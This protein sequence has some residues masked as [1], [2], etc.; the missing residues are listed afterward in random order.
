M[1]STVTVQ[2][3][4]RTNVGLRKCIHVEHSQNEASLD[5][6]IIEGERE[7][8]RSENIMLKKNLHLEREKTI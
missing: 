2:K 4:G 6:E 1:F 8:T 3:E 5:V 7:M